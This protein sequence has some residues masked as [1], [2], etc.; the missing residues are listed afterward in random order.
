MP[1]LGETPTRNPAADLKRHRTILVVD[2]QRSIREMVETILTHAG[3]KVMLADDGKKAASL[4]EEHAGG[5]D[6]VLSDLKMPEMNGRVL[7][8]R[9][10]TLHP[11]PRYILM[12][13]TEPPEGMEDVPFLPKP[14]SLY[15]LLDSIAETLDL[16]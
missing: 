5:I 7:L 10:R 13:A 6:L 4:I 12:S 16:K 15:R 8:D 1:S 2:D 9:L 11:P 3:Y 14:F